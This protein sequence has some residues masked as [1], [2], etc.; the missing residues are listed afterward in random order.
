ML[1]DT[2]KK[3]PSLLQQISLLNRER[4]ALVGNGKII[5]N[6]ASTKAK[7]ILLL[8]F[9]LLQILGLE[10]NVLAQTG[11]GISMQMVVRDNNQNLLI[12][13]NV[14]LRLSIHKDVANGP[15]IFQE[16]QTIKSNLQGLIK[17][18]IGSG[19]F[20]FGDL[21]SINW[22]SAIYYLQ[23]EVDPL[24]GNKWS[25]N[26][27]VPIHAVPYAMHAGN[28]V[29]ANAK[30]GQV[31]SLCDG[32][33]TW[34][35]CK[36]RIP[37]VQTNVASEVTD[38]S[39]S[40]GGSILESGGS[41]VIARGIC[42]AKTPNPTLWDKRSEIAL[43]NTNFTSSFT[44]LDTNT[45]YYARAY[46]S[47][48]VGTGYGQQ[49]TFKTLAPKIDTLLKIGM[50]YQGGIIAYLLKEGDLGY[51]PKIQQG[52]IVADTDFVKGSFNT[53]A[54]RKEKDTITG[55]N[56]TEIGRGLFNTGKIIQVQEGDSNSTYAALNCYG[57]NRNGFEDWYLPSRDELNQIYQNKD[58]IGHMSAANYWSST[59][60][61]EHSAFIQNFGT[62]V[63]DIC[64][65]DALCRVRPIRAIRV[66][67][68]FSY[69]VNAQG[70]K[71]YND[72][73]VQMVY[74]NLGRMGDLVAESHIKSALEYTNICQNI[75]TPPQQVEESL[76]LKEII[77]MFSTCFEI[78]VLVFA[79]EAKALHMAARIISGVSEMIFKEKKE[80]LPENIQG[81]INNVW[82]GLNTTFDLVKFRLDSYRDSLPKYWF[83]Q[84]RS[85]YSGEV[86]SFGDLYKN[87]YLPAK[88][89]TD[90]DSTKYYVSKVAKYEMTKELLHLRWNIRSYAIIGDQRTN[91][92]KW[93]TVYRTRWNEDALWSDDYPVDKYQNIYYFQ[94]RT[95]NGALDKA[96]QHS[97]EPYGKALY[98][99][100]EPYTD[101]EIKNWLTNNI[102]YSGLKVY[103]WELA[104]SVN[105]PS[106]TAPESL[107]NWLFKDDMKGFLVRPSAVTTRKDVFKNW[108]LNVYMGY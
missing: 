36:A 97:S 93:Q 59:E 83:T 85:V 42:Y 61:N 84:F 48:S 88:N 41:R 104:P 39:A 47:N 95:L 82:D 13:K 17:L 8:S 25:I 2:P 23:T 86:V 102:Q 37:L 40:I 56:A 96:A 81:E 12:E 101:P 7:S 92:N 91:Y 5:S 31:L 10:Q 106:A 54:W 62:G 67:P 4:T 18:E 68:D 44:N 103:L 33:A 75:N 105:Y 46:A 65:K 50:Y 15:I 69:I 63:Q 22:G 49:I 20:G 77:G 76:V 71:I 9:F 80:N 27:S 53:F 32:V 26:S 38:R 43:A 35:P 16:L 51:N 57:L 78:G 94:D 89:Q 34:E 100:T 3:K 29:P 24:G 99:W 14:A 66:Y 45:L 1:S 90:F 30:N 60:V 19:V 55:G 98:Y 58:L 21:D 11:K 6:W 79:P 87:G 52:F 73:N 107:I 108:G 72:S 64:F 70:E 74:V 28:G